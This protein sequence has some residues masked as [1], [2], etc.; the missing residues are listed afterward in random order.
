MEKLA[1]AAGVTIG[2]DPMGKRPACTVAPPPPPPEPE[3][4]EDKAAVGDKG[5]AAADN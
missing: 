4:S 5:A 2:F 3:T 1:L